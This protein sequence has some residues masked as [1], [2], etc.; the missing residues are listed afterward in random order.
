MSIYIVGERGQLGRSLIEK[1][2][3]V[4]GDHELKT[5]DVVTNC[6]A[7]TDHKECNDYPD[8]AWSA[9]VDLVKELVSECFHA[10]A[11]LIH[12]TSDYALYPS[13][14]NAYSTTKFIAEKYLEISKFKNWACVRISWLFSPYKKAEFLS[15]PEVWH[16]FGSPV[17]APNFADALIDFAKRDKGQK[18][19]EFSGGASSREEMAKY[20]QGK[21]VGILATP[22]D[23]PGSTALTSDFDWNPRPLTPFQVVEAYKKVHG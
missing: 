1:G 14:D 19:Y 21:S 3:L 17:W 11:F 15:L 4:Y 6:A 12:I 13:T 23:R 10:D 22:N 2:C 18:F 20:Y 7:K 8:Y 16:Q 5:G 9:N